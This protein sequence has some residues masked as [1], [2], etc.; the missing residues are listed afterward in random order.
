MSLPK[1]AFEPLG[2]RTPPPRDGWARWADWVWAAVSRVHRGTRKPGNWV[3]LFK[4]GVVGGSGYAINL[5]AFA[6]LNS[7]A[8]L[9]HIAAAVGAFLVAVTNNFAWNRVWTFRDDRSG[10][11][12]AHQG[13]RFLAV[14]VGGL[15]I[16]L[17]VLQLLVAGAALAELPSQAIAV[18]VAMPANFIGNKL[19]TFSR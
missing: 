6:L 7:G 1:P 15:A 9:G 18:A 8:D 4:F 5:V 16:N 11:R 10:T 12:T 13:A 19:W 14:S 2:R 3:Q 17:A